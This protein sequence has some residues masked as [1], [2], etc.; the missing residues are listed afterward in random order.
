MRLWIESAAVY[1]GTYG[2]LGSGIY[3]VKF[4]EATMRRHCG[5]CHQTD[6][7][8]YRNPKAGAIYFQFGK[9]GPPQPLLT[10]PYDIIL[11]RHLAYLQLG[12]APLHQELCNLDRPER[13]LLLCAP[14]GRAAGGLQLCGQPIFGDRADPDYREMLAA[15]QDASQRLLQ[16]KRFD[17]PGFRPNRFYIREMQH[18]H[19]LPATLPDD[20]IVDSYTTDRAYWKTLEYGVA[21]GHG[22]EP[23]PALL[24][25]FPS[26]PLRRCGTAGRPPIRLASERAWH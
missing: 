8:P 6:Q 13:S 10:D 7:P 26:P 14:L 22:Q 2:T 20:V 1:P 5:V 16:H 19:I 4:P 11:I 17:M 12:E 3:P 23:Y 9:R 15:I 25:A 21:S 24:R 18:F